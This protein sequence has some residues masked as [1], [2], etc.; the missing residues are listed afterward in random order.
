MNFSLLKE[1]YFTSFAF[2]NI[3]KNFNL[4]LFYLRSLLRET[5]Q[6]GMQNIS[7]FK[8]K[9]SSFNTNGTKE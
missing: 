6:V 1:L 7:I 8:G 9:S 3:L 4:Y 5:G 2:K